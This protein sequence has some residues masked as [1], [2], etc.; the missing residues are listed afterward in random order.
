M[1]RPTKAQRNDTSTYF[2]LCLQNS[3]EDSPRLGKSHASLL[4]Q[5]IKNLYIKAYKSYHRLAKYHDNTFSSAHLNPVWYPKSHKDFLTYSSPLNFSSQPPGTSTMAH[6]KG[7]QQC[8]LTFNKPHPPPHPKSWLS[9]SI[10]RYRGKR[11]WCQSK[12]LG[13]FMLTCVKSF[14]PPASQMCSCSSTAFDCRS[15]DPYLPNMHFCAQLVRD[16]DN[17]TIYF[18]PLLHEVI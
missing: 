10:G 9:W 15:F 4:S 1:K 17:K 16:L 7:K 11:M 18:L 2:F 13:H 14:T 5:W 3:L 8:D 12:A 6:K